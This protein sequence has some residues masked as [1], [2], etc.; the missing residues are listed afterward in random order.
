MTA[1]SASEFDEV[2]NRVEKLV[3]RVEG[4]IKK[5]FD[6]CNDAMRWLPS[7]IGE[8]IKPALQKIAELQR[9]FFEEIGKFFTE[10]GSPWGLWSAGDRW[11]E[12][13]GG[14]ASKL[15]GQFTPGQLRTTDDWKG[16]AADAYAKVLPD[17]KAALEALKKTAD[18][19]N[20]AMKN[21]AYAIGAY[22]LGLAIAVATFVAE[23]IP[24]ST[25]ASTGVGAAPAAAGA[26]VSTAKVVGL[27][28]AIGGALSAY[29][30]IVVNQ[31]S[32]LENELNN[33]AG[34]PGGHWPRATSDS[35]HDEH[36]WEVK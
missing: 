31:V 11:S 1:M 3:H 17:Q 10:W 22:W 18:T 21:L 33:D 5:I 35:M 8:I 6:S 34:L 30:M 2:F 27:V 32:N 25:A 12:E 28:A 13:I 4:L 19:I 36:N 9:R 7:E 20:S 15:A 14:V 24:E 29:M 16:A 26:A 23:L